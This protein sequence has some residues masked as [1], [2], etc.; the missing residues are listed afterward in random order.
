MEDHKEKMKKTKAQGRLLRLNRY[1][2]NQGVA[3]RRK[4]D[5][6]IR[7]SRVYI[8]GSL[9]T[10]LGVK[11][12]PEKDRVKVGGKLIGSGAKRVYFIFNKPR[13]VLTTTSDPK[14]RSTVLDYFKKVKT[15][16]FPVGR[17][18]WGSEGLLIMTNDGDLAWKITNPKSRIPKTY[19][20]KL[21][22]L[23]S[24]EKLEKLKRGVSI[25]GGK[26]KAVD[27]RLIKKKSDKKDWVQI[28]IN[29]GKNRQVRK[30]FEKIGFDV[31]RLRRVAIGRLKLSGLKLGEYRSLEQKD[32]EKLQKTF[33]TDH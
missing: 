18:D 20:A 29:E 12:D 13:N 14:G 32:L 22:A 33:R 5:E 25:V 8:N 26:V 3:S 7:D 10:E 28:T 11:I 17:L 6:L 15:R 27:V 9:V 16:I 30:M 19:H 4:A 24:K 21:D 31:V 23:V 1:L 2:A